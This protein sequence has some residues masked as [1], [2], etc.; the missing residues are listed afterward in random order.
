MI[1]LRNVAD[2]FVDVYAWDGATGAPK[3]GDASNITGKIKIGTA[4]IASTNDTNPTELSSTD[5]PGMYRFD[6]TQAETNA[7]QITLYSKSSTANILIRPVV[8]TTTYSSATLTSAI[9]TELSPE[10]NFIDV[11]ISSRATLS[12]SD[13]TNHIVEGTLTVDNVLRIL[14][15]ALAGKATENTNS[16]AAYRDVSD[17]KDRITATVD[18]Y[19]NRT[20]VTIDGD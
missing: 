4:A 5:M 1:L 20:S 16:Y 18:M 19:G 8:I 11:A 3:T 12:V 6:L 7:L 2:Q 15:A 13:I 17:S 10:L 14:L 9:R